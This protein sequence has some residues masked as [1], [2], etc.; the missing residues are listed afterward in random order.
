MPQVHLTEGLFC[1]KTNLYNPSASRLLVTSLYTR[2][3][4]AHAHFVNAFYIL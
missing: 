3:L 1:F 2:G 4:K